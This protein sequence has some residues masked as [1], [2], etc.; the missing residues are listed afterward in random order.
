MIFSINDISIWDVFSPWIWILFYSISFVLIAFPNTSRIWP[1]S[2]FSFLKNS[3]RINGFVALIFV[4]LIAIPNFLVRVSA[5]EKEKEALARNNFSLKKVK[6]D[7]RQAQQKVGFTTFPEMTLS[8]EGTA[9]NLPGSLHGGTELLPKIRD[10][11]KTDKLYN[12]TISDGV[13]LQINAV[14]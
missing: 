6:Y 3:G 13:I 2:Q 8:F 14:E 4:S 11:L 12:I 7:G 5:L 10:E 1:L 9:Y